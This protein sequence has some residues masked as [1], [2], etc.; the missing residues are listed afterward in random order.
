MIK[1]LLLVGLGGGIGSVLRY[2]IS[3]LVN[4]YN[5]SLFPWATLV[6]N[7]LGC[8]IIGVILGLFEKQILVNT[9][10]KHLFIVGF[11][12]GFTTFSAFAAENFNLLQ[13][14]NTLMALTYVLASVVGGLL[15][16]WLGWM[17]VK[18]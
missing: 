9:S 4:K 13:S 12:G 16:L 17:M 18:L 2:L 14:G 3:V 1:T 6:V 10:F 5:V 15:A 8:L 7:L 11:C